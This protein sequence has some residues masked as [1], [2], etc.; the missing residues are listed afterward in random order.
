MTIVVITEC[1]TKCSLEFNK[2]RTNT[3]WLMQH[4]YLGQYDTSWIL[5]KL[6]LSIY[7]YKGV[8]FK[9]TVM[10]CYL[11]G[12]SMAICHLC[13]HPVVNFCHLCP[14]TLSFLQWKVWHDFQIYY[15]VFW[16]ILLKTAQLSNCIT[17]NFLSPGVSLVWIWAVLQYFK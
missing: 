2:V 17:W 14:T 13:H 7:L 8:Q 16:K 12:S 3:P 15:F 10:N 1:F 4:L 5:H 11:I 6:D 9:S